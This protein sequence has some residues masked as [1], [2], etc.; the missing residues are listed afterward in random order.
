MLE[1]K[2]ISKSFEGVHALKN[3]SMTFY[4]GEIH[5]L[6]GSNG[7]GKSTL[8]KIVSGVYSPDSGSIEINGKQAE[9][10]TPVDAY[11]AGIRIVHQELSLIRSLSIAENMFIHKF[12][13]G[14]AFKYVNRK[15]HEEHAKSVLSKWD[16][17]ADPSIKVAEVSMG[18]RQQ[19]EIARELS[20]GGNII[21]LDEPTSSLTDKEIKQLF[22]FIRI[23]RDKGLIVIFISHRFNEVTELVDRMTVLRDGEVV[24]TKEV[25]SIDVSEF[26]NLV[27]GKNVDDLFPK[28]PAE[29]GS[30]ALEITNF[31]GKGFRNI[32]LEVKWGEI[33]G[34]AGLMGSG[35]S[36]L[37][38]AIFG[39]DKIIAGELI[40]EGKKSN[41]K[42]PS[43]AIQA[44]LLLL[45]ENRTEEGIFPHLCVSYNFVVMK[46]SDY[47]GKLF[48]EPRKIEQKVGHFI[49]KLN[50]V[51]R[52]PLVQL[53]SE[54]SGG[55]QQ[56][57]V[58]GRLLGADPK[59]LL[60]DEPTRGIDIANKIEI[61]KIMGDVVS[62]GGAI[63]I[64]SSELEELIGI[65][66][67]ILV[68]H[69]GAGNG[70]FQRTEFHKETILGCMM[71][72]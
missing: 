9:F 18:I 72:T 48:L 28:V 71:G 63:V 55:N 58:L 37:L 62:H 32:N 22:A 69:E 21:I 19:V 30:K 46:L 10:G 60:L 12:T 13:N 44:G 59:I 64:V 1:V 23:L 6:L 2:D 34:I 49:K 41:F 61:H 8:M 4:D 65:C 15:I 45:S 24:G 3:V 20:T 14:S 43:A 54:L 29:I 68:L 25:K 52:S 67:K 36:E 39:I 26:C 5:G 66:D 31:T 11:G 50:I 38:R 42:S 35:R 56:K 27:S 53:I 51:A 7:A 17:D 33:V 40:L 70:M 47:V 16:V 57:V